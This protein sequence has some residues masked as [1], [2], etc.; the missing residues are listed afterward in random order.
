MSGNNRR[1]VDLH[2]HVFTPACLELVEGLMA[3]E[4]EPFSY[5]G[6]QETNAYQVGH[7][8]SIM[9]KLT[10]PAVRIADMDRM[11]IDVQALSVAPPQFYYWTDP[12]LGRRL[13]RLQ[14]EHL[15]ELVAGNPDRFVGLATV[16]MQDVSS[17]VAELEYAVR[18]LGFRGAEINTNIAGLDLDDRRYRPFFAKAEELDVV[19]LLHPNGFTHGERLMKY[20]L[21]NVLGNPLDTTVAL[22]RIIHGGVLEDHP[23]LK[24]CFVHGGGYLPFYS[25]RMDHAYEE[26][27][28]GRHHISRPPSTYLKQVY[29]DCLVF[30]EVHLEFLLKK[31]GPDHVVVGTDYPF[32][33]GYYDP[34]GQL[35]RVPGLSDEEREMV[36]GGTAAR[37][38]KLDR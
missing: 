3:P 27:P 28:E 7:V 11:G 6:G 8:K 13:A 20:Y 12:E 1:T 24:L 32:D 38:L 21:T 15:A 35:D 16:P 9:P 26:R 17:A 33:M 4:M 22:T 36:R 30:D 31:M 29:V 18:E 2:A 19:V 14:N 10:D 25:S 37:L 5:F 34:L 23:E